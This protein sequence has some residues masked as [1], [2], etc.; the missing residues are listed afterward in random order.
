MKIT[1][2]AEPT[3][4]EPTCAEPKLKLRKKRSC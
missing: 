2:K 1:I 4:A 3:C